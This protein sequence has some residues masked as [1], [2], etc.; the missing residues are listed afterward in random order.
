MK[1]LDLDE[2]KLWKPKRLDRKMYA[3]DGR[4]FMWHIFAYA[5]CPAENHFLQIF[6]NICVSDSCALLD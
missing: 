5:L 3:A 2:A 1:E 4:N 6:I